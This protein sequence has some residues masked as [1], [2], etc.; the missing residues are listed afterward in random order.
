MLT[1]RGWLF[2][3]PAILL[4][5]GAGLLPPSG[6]PTLLAV[7]LTLL[8]WFMG[9]WLVFAIRVRAAVARLT[10]E[11]EVHD[12]RGPVDSLWARR[13]FQVRG[14][15]RVDGLIGLPYV[16]AVDHVPFGVEAAEGNTRFEGEVRPGRP[17]EFKYRVYCPA[18]G[19]IRFE[20]IRVQV[21]DLQGFFYHVAF[22]SDARSYR[23][24]PMLVDAEGRGPTRKRHNLLPPPGVH[25][26]RRPG[27]GSELL[28]LRDYL[29]G[30]PPKMIAWKV[31]A[32]RDRLIT[33]EFESEVPVRCT[34]FVDTSN[35][36]RLGPPGQNALSR[37]V[38]IAAAV[39]QATVGARDLIGL[40]IF[41]EET[42]SEL[43][44]ARTRQHLSEVLNRLADAAGLAPA[45]GK[46]PIDGLVPAAYAFA[47]EV[48]P[49]L[50][51]KEINAFPFW[52]AW[53]KPRAS[54]TIRHPTASDRL[55]R[56][57]P[58]WL[59]LYV[60]VACNLWCAGL[61]Y[62]AS[63]LA[64]RDFGGSMSVV[65][66]LLC[67]F[68]MAFVLTRV[69]SVLLFPRQRRLL[70]WRKQ[71]AALLSVRHG[72]AP[73]GLGLLLE[74][75]DLFSL[76]LQRFLAEHH[77]PCTLPLFDRKG[78]Y[79]FAA[80]AKVEVLARHLTR[81]VA[82][83]HDN[84][85]FVLLV[86]L[87]EIPEHLGPLFRA[88]KVALGRHHQVMVVCPWPPGMPP[89]PR[90]AG[91]P[92][93]ALVPVAPAAGQIVAL[94]ELLRQATTLRFQEAFHRLRRGFARLNVPVLCAQHEDPAALI[95]ERLD[96]LRTVRSGPGER[97]T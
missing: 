50:L 15:L 90:R 64:W 89:P 30:D 59:A 62:L 82:R 8:L 46:A 83:S 52:L 20:G 17:V 38:D 60:L 58:L 76:H 5:V 72:L 81:A 84:E 23:V 45:Q 48:Y 42:A 9:Q 69:G 57:L 32:R 85:L 14:R 11:R 43:R 75:D 21:A 7:G 68:I 35:S 18:T 28:D 22:V 66:F 77:V 3:I 91:R 6:H 1:S 61:V 19:Q 2:L 24:M 87:L 67:G 26:L 37:Q 53:L 93:S 96:R 80:P 63:Q 47:E 10:V 51:R 12:E 41:D 13:S 29:P 44:P 73:G 79:L 34:L 49:H 36:V 56:W 27:T 31:S 86:D 4:V 16:L 70:R 40:C 92:L 39:A 65:F 88:V 71:L 55:N 54:F 74:D 94:A 25:R 95:V 33:K 97:G 78:R